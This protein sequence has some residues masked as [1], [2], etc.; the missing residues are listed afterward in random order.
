MKKIIAV[1]L[2]LCIFT[3]MAVG[4]AAAKSA[5]VTSAQTQNSQACG[6]CPQAS[7]SQIAG[8][9]FY[10]GC[11]SKVLVA[12]GAQKGCASAFVGTASVCNSQIICATV[13]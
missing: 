9:G 12:G 6:I 4:T 3:A 7:S 5:S 13:C 1:T 2:M 8:A 10:E 11:Y